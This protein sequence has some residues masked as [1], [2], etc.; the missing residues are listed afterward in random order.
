MSARPVLLS[1]CT[2]LLLTAACSNVDVDATQEGFA[3]DAVEISIDGKGKLTAEEVAAIEAKPD[4]EHVLRLPQGSCPDGC[5]FAMVTVY[6]DNTTG[7]AMAP[8]VVRLAS[9]AQ[10]PP[11]GALAF[12]THEISVGRKGR[13]RWLVELWPGEQTL[14]THISSSVFLSAA[15]SS[16]TSETAKAPANQTTG[17]EKTPPTAAPAVQ[18]P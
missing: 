17:P 12:G 9:P 18:T 4:V 14:R 13:L 6:V 7:A 3:D 8:P 2:L 1:M 15:P 10:R 16:T 11:R 5:E